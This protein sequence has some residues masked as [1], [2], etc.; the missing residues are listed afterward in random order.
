MMKLKEKNR[1]A[2]VR[3]AL[4]LALV[5]NGWSAPMADSNSTATASSQAKASCKLGDLS[6]FRTIANDVDALV[7]KGNLPG[8]KKRIK[9]LETSWDE[10]EAGIKP[11]D[12][13]SWHVLDK[14]IDRALAALRAK[15]PNQPECKSAIAALLK[16]F[17]AL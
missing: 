16:A 17:D 2:A 15:T 13:K 7:E 6:A 10:A 14:A 11:R 4:L 5:T 9:D 3:V 8:A 1:I 12:A